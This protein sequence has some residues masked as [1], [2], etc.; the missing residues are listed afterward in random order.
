MTEL[1]GIFSA[2]WADYAAFNPRAKKIYDLIFAR[3][4]KNNPLLERLSNDHIALRTYN[5][6]PIGLKQISSL[7][8][9]YGY[10][11]KGDYVFEDK[12]LFAW[13]LEHADKNLPKIFIS[14]LECE[15]LSSFVL[16]TAI[17]VTK[18]VDS[19]KAAHES[20]L[21]SGRPWPAE[22]SVYQKLLK[23]S[24]YAAWLYAFGFRA[25][26]FTIS[27]ND[28]QTFSGLTELNEFIVANG[29]ELNS[30]GGIIKGTPQLF[31]EQSSTMAEKAQV[32]FD[33]GQFQIPSCYYEFA[34]RH[35][36]P[37]GKLYQGFVTASAD[38]IFE[39][40]DVISQK[41]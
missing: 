2:L 13:H 5:R 6:S 28:L 8:E 39:S 22:H 34:L 27:V 31:L 18:A 24:E 15:K 19:K 1:E 35:K 10:E 9:K 26:H 7:F 30:A 41:R 38:K 16:E 40:T 3:E 23:E 12:K 14:E 11:K 25:N 17:Q 20:L 29:F 37:S 4:K 33:D 32:I 21:W 36:L